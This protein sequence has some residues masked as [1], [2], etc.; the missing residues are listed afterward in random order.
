MSKKKFVKAVTSRD[1]DFAQWYTDVVLKTGLADYAPVKGCMVIR[2]YGF[3]LW[4]NIKD[5]AD[6]KFKETGHQNAYFP[7]LI[8]ENFLRKEAEHFEGFSPEV[9]WVT[10]GGDK[11]L[12]ERLLIRPTSETMICTMYAKWIQSYRDLPVLMN[13]WCNVVRWEK[14]TRPFL[15]TSEFLWQEGHTVHETKQEAEEET[16]RMLEIY[17]QLA[18]E[19]M[20]MP[21]ILGRKSEKEKFAGADKTYTMEAMMYDGKALQAGTSHYLAENFSRM[22]GITFLGRDGQEHYGWSTSWGVS[23]R[24]IGGLIMVHGDDRG[25][26]IPP[27]VAPTQVVIVPIGLEKGNIGEKADEI[28]ARLKD[29]FRVKLDT[30]EEYSIGWK[31]NEWEMKGIPVRLE[32]GNKELSEG[33]ITAFRRDKLEKIKLSFD[34]LEQELEDL[35]NTIQNDMYNDAK[36]RM[37]SKIY[38]FDDYDKLKEWSKDSNGFAKIM[39]SGD[40][41]DEEKLREDTGLTIRC[42]PFDEEKISDK[43]IISGKD[44]KHMVYVAKAY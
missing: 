27:K 24:L 25:L 37:E 30:R 8:P 6:R 19:N 41:E 36:E 3:A 18:E 17:R 21:V 44:A 40:M 13:Q 32:F 20:A 35:L 11:E 42:I 1:D 5:I 39:W 23:T 2:P 34:N 9:L 43:C 7:L 4:E 22:F 10:Q 15:R 28:Y 31:F 14:T 26:R 16:L 12:T 33:Y 38:K 29:K